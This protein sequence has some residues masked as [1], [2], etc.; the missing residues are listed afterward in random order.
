M[1]QDVYVLDLRA[2]GLGGHPLGVILD[3]DQKSV[4]DIPPAMAPPGAG[5]LAAGGARDLARE[6]EEGKG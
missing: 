3:L 1:L 5:G 4:R 2:A 6:R